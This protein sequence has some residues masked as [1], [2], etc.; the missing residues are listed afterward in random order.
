MSNNSDRRGVAI[1]YHSPGH[2]PIILP[3]RYSL[4]ANVGP[5]DP[6]DYK[7]RGRHLQ[8]DDLIVLIGPGSGPERVVKHLRAIAARIERSGLYTGEKGGFVR[9]VARQRVDRT[10][11]NTRRQIRGS[12]NAD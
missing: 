1:G 5:H 2:D 6:L 7:P 9:V 11:R 8:A 4:S 10:K 3:F 12:R